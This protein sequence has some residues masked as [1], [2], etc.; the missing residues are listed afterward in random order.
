MSKRCIVRDVAAAVYRV[1]I[2]EG[3]TDHTKDLSNVQNTPRKPRRTECMMTVR[4]C[5]HCTEEKA[6]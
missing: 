2:L 3:L 6:F 5:E 1:P 4:I